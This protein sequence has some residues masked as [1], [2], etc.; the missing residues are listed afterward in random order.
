[1]NYMIRAFTLRR[2]N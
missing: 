2:H 1:M